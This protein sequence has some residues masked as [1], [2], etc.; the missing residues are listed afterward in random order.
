MRKSVILLMGMLIG[1][2]WLNGC[3][4]QGIKLVAPLSENLDEASVY[5]LHRQSEGSTEVTIYLDPT[6]SEKYLTTG[7]SGGI[8]GRASIDVHVGRGISNKLHEGLK[9]VFPKVRFAPTELTPVDSMTMKIE[10]KEVKIGFEFSVDSKGHG[11]NETSLMDKAWINLVA[12]TKVQ[13][14]TGKDVSRSDLTYK[15]TKESY[16]NQLSYRE[17]I[18]ERSLNKVTIDLIRDIRK[19]IN[20]DHPWYLSITMNE[21]ALQ[22][23]PYAG[24]GK[25][26]Q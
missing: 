19:A 18:L 11:C 2:E 1:L 24:A 26:F 15:D 14:Q 13:D 12:A 8:C 22:G 23:N 21:K 16:V 7:A 10:I 20:Q 4:G 25:S 6:M 3:T 17:E 5:F 9:E